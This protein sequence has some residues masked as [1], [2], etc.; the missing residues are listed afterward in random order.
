MIYLKCGIDIQE[1]MVFRDG[2]GLSCKCQTVEK[3]PVDHR[4]NMKTD[5]FVDVGARCECCGQEMVR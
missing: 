4:Y 3:C 2:N 1:N 5:C